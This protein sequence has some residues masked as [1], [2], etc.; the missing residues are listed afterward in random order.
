VDHDSSDVY[1]DTGLPRSQQHPGAIIGPALQVKMGS[2]ADIV[3]G[4]LAGEIAC[5]AS[6]SSTPPSL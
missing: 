2:S 4:M 3:R 1:S 6:R 5:S